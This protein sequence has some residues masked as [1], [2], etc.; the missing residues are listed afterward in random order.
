MS[1]A[2]RDSIQEATDELRLQQERLRS[3]RGNLRDVTTKTRSR[4]GMVTVTIGGRGEV[5][6]IA[7][8]TQKFRKMA[9]AELGAVLVETIGKAREQSRD[10]VIAAYR[11]FLPE[12][13]D[14]E[15]VLAGKTDVNR[16]VDDAI[17][18]V[19]EIMGAGRPADGG[20]RPARGGERHG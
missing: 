10:R 6:S 19:G 14:L 20:A 9:P 17:R 12:T 1:T 3:V 15:N 2:M 8:N 7:F 11:S 13:M 4:D 16:L 18:K 5:T